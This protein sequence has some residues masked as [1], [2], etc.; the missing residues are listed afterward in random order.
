MN[1]PLTVISYS[2]TGIDKNLIEKIQNNFPDLKLSPYYI[3]QVIAKNADSVN[4][5]I[6]YGVDFKKEAEINSVF[7]E[8]YEKIKDKNYSP[9]S[10]ITGRIT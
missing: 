10:V 8:A 5:A 6:L 2:P 9:F 4:G 1:Y 3:T 7:K